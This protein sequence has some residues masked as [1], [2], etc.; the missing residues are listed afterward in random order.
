MSAATVP[1][2]AD[3]T[4][5]RP[6]ARA[7]ATRLSLATISTRLVAFSAL[8]AFASLQWATLV[9][10][11]EPGR[12]LGMAA[13]AI[14]A[15]IL[16]H[17]T[18][19]LP[20]LVRHP[21]TDVILVAALA[22]CLLASGLPRAYLAPNAWSS[23][24]DGIGQGLQTL[25][26]IT[27][28]YRG[29][30]P[31]VRITILTGGGALLLLG[32]MLAVRSART[33][34]RP[35]GAAIVLST[36]YGVSIVVHTPSHA[37]AGGALFAILL[38][39]VLWA[40]RV[41]RVRAVP[42]LAFVLLA[43]LAGLAVAPVIDGKQ[44]LLDYER[45]AER[46]TTPPSTSFDWNHGYG[47]LDWP[48]D[49]REI[50]RVS[51]ATSSYWKA[52][53]L[54]RFDGVR[55][56]QDTAGDGGIDT[57][58]SRAHPEWRRRI[59][60]SIRNLRSS[61]YVG[62]GVTLGIPS[63]P[64]LALAATP[65]TFVTGTSPLRRGDTYEADVYVPKPST[66][67][68]AD[69][70]T[71]Y[72]AFTDR[73][74]TMD[75]PEVAGGPSQTPSPNAPSTL[76]IPPATLRF[77]PFG[78]EGTAA[79]P[80][81]YAPGFAGQDSVAAIEASQYGRVWRLAQQLKEK[82]K[83]PYDYLRA[84]E[85]HLRDGFTYTETPPVHRIELPAFLFEDKAGY[86]QQFS[87]AMALLLRMGGVPARVSAGFAT[88]VYDPRRKQYVAR[89]L[90]AHSWVEAYFPSYGWV[91]FDPTPQS[92]P[93]RGQLT[94]AAALVEAGGGGAPVVPNRGAAPKIEDAGTAATTDGG[95]FPWKTVAIVAAILAL[96]AA[97]GALGLRALRR[98]PDDVSPELAELARALRRT[99][100][101]APPPLTLV[102]LE[103]RFARG[104][105][106]AAAYVAKVRAARYAGAA[107]GPT[108]AERS[109][110]RR[111]LAAGL[112]PLGRLRAWWALPPRRIVS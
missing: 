39:S 49:G 65:G 102:G 32:A 12:L 67:E 90:D 76:R 31:W 26:G 20:G 109:A 16:V 85:D 22:G 82:A 77:A 80:L 61:K 36:I 78:T 35:L 18:A 51:S 62:A 105:R 87:G 69:A 66:E 23:L 7:A 95:S 43:A 33:G 103:Q 107:E 83:T 98:L 101:E 89:D 58:I 56:L 60:V 21:A 104:D 71:R 108:D 57:E 30:D 111:E 48:R 25:P 96:L 2:G 9:R 54:P 11:H 88:G 112:G 42:A 19:R 6:A 8:A 59:T 52:T 5:P 50:L 93:P 3:P 34:G 74:L 110:L 28:P 4:S 41:E 29:I 14:A 53:D 15:A 63:P 106:G 24:A 45:L 46:L 81:L 27:V 10:P 70:G 68:M 99:G 72:P 38:G 100:R 40:D 79:N 55:W 97:L 91:S 84:I 73:Y 86:C 37:F 94:P 64:R 75:L 47:P 17:A 13:I 92:A 44:P 1:G